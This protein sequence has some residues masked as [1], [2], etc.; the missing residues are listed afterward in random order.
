MIYPQKPVN[1]QILL[2]K[3]F[4]KRE[5]Q[6]DSINYTKYTGLET[7]IETD[8]ARAILGR[9]STS[10]SQHIRGEIR[11]VVQYIK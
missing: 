1:G 2:R 11:A 4:I 6:T 7:R 3:L 10:S 8:L 5:E 9:I